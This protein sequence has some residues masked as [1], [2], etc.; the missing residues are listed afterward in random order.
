MF[1]IYVYENIYVPKYTYRGIKN[2]VQQF[3]LYALKNVSYLN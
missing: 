3:Q 1:Y 2:R